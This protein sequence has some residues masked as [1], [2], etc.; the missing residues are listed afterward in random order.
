MAFSASGDSSC[1]QN[2]MRLITSIS[3]VIGSIAL[4][5]NAM[6]LSSSG[7][8]SRRCLAT[9]FL[10]GCPMAGSF[11]PSAGPTDPVAT[12]GSGIRP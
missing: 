11:P 1:C 10:S 4:M 6:S 2:R 3:R 9:V 12:E 7:D 8:G 5:I